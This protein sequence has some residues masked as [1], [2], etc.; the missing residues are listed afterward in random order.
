MILSAH[1]IDFVVQFFFRVCARVW[2]YKCKKHSFVLCSSNLAL[3]HW[4]CSA[5]MH[6]QTGKKDTQN[7]RAKKRKFYQHKVKIVHT[8]AHIQ[9]EYSMNA[10]SMRACKRTNEHEMRNQAN[11]TNVIA[12]F[13]RIRTYFIQ[14]TLTH[15]YICYK[16]I[17]YLIT[18]HVAWFPVNGNYHRICCTFLCVCVLK[19][20]FIIKPLQSCHGCRYLLICAKNIF[21]LLLCVCAPLTSNTYSQCAKAKRPKTITTHGKKQSWI[22]LSEKQCKHLI[23]M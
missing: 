7:C 2:V 16:I 6:R 12:T 22:V 20:L 1:T 8:H 15:T 13:T 9:I 11:Q 14:H 21:R 18:L 4:R 17:M 19:T 5:Y 10:I 23:C 3:I